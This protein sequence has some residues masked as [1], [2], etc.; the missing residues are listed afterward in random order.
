VGVQREL[1]QTQCEALTR[2]PR[3]PS[4]SRGKRRFL[5]FLRLPP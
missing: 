1:D 2:A 3:L 4:Q 5:P